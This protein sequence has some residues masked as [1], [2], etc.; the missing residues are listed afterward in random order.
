VTD[1]SEK[2]IG[3]DPKGVVRKEGKRQAKPSYL[4]T[5]R[6]LALSLQCTAPATWAQSAEAHRPRAGTRHK[7]TAIL[8]ISA[9]LDEVLAL[10]DASP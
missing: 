6:Y 8:L 10:S 1:S 7:G 3:R 5:A 9:D 2:S 4:I